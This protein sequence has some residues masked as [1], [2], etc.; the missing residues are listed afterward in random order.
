MALLSV[1]GLPQGW[2]LEELQ[3]WSSAG[4]MCSEAPTEATTSVFSPTQGGFSMGSDGQ[5]ISYFF[6]T[7]PGKWAGTS[8][9]FTFVYK[10]SSGATQS[11]S[12]GSFTFPKE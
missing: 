12:S 8:V 7:P 11:V 4:E 3:A 2:T 1:R 5:V 9:Y 6:P 10:T